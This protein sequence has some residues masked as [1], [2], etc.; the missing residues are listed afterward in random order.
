MV[1]PSRLGTVT[2][3]PLSLPTRNRPITMAPTIA[4][5]MATKESIQ[6]TALLRPLRPV[7]TL[8]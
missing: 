7:E 6:K 8:V 1:R 3:V 5:E 4:A 2:T